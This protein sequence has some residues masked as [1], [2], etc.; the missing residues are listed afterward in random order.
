MVRRAL[1]G[2]LSYRT[3]MAARGI[4]YVAVGRVNI[5]LTWKVRQAVAAGVTRPVCIPMAVSLV[6]G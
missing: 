5:P 1:S 6:L 2:C 4:D 3:L